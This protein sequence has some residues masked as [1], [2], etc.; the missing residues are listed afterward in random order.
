MICGDFNA[1]NN[2]REIE[3]L[4][5]LIHVKDAYE[6]G[7]G[8]YPRLDSENDFQI[9]KAIDHIFVTPDATNNYPRFTHSKIVLNVPDNISGIYPSDHPAVL[10]TLHDYA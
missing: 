5:K 1:E 7:G 2:S 8:K 6:L 4:K 9:K 10:T 3:L